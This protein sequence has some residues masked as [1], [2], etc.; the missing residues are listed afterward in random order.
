MKDLLPD[1][2]TGFESEGNTV[3]ESINFIL[4]NFSEMNWLWIRL[5][6]QNSKKDKAGREAEREELW[7][8]VGESISRLSQLESVDEKMYLTHVLPKLL[9]TIV[10]CKDTMS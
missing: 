10:G 3:I 7:V 4:R 2:N 6:Y 8:T 9:E 1:K 5:Q